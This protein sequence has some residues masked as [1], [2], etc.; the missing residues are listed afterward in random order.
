MHY[1]CSYSIKSAFNNR[2]SSILRKTLLKITLHLLLLKCWANSNLTNNFCSWVVKTIQGLK[3]IL[4]WVKSTTKKCKVSNPLVLYRQKQKMP[5]IL[6]KQL[7]PLEKD[8]GRIEII[9]SI[10]LSDISSFCRL[11]ES[12]PFCLTNIN[13]VY[14]PSRK[15]KLLQKFCK[16]HKLPKQLSLKLIQE[17]N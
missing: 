12:T 8:H 9:T 10:S 15:K 17:A 2:F 3:V 4:K 14:N 1:T 16:S 11:V 7:R 13:L 6:I 5:I